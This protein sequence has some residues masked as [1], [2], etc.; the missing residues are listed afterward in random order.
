M[1]KLRNKFLAGKLEESKFR[2]VGFKIMQEN[3]SIVIDQSDYIEEVENER[4]SPHRASQKTDMLS[5][6]ELSSLRSLVGRLNW[7][8]QGTRPDLAFEMVELSTKFKS[9]TV[10]DMLRAI[11]AIRKLKEERGFVV[12]PNMGDSK[13]WKMV[14]FSD[15]A[16]ANL[17]DGVSSMGAHLVLL[18]GEDGKCCTLTWHAGKIKRVVRSTIAAEALSLQEGLENGMF[19]R[20]HVEEMLGMKTG[21]IPI[22]AFTDNKS[23]VQAVHSTSLVDDK[24]L[25]IDIGA[26]RESLKRGEIHAVKWCPGEMQ[27]ADCMTKKG[28][29]G[30]KLLKLIQM[31]RLDYM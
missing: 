2:Y 12:F 6:Q 18:V 9:G 29:A 13:K 30:Y 19:L 1:D 31:G 10:T 20:S 21:S 17:N 4:L 24:R 22:T 28:A 5:S 27:M 7:V 15:A 3:E 8:V 23:V 16:H 11:K 26:I 25:R 14:I